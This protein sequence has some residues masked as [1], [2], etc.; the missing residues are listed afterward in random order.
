M[1]V[2]TPPHTLRYA[3]NYGETTSTRVWLSIAALLQALGYAMG[4]PGGYAYV[5][6]T[7]MK[8]LVPLWA[9]CLA[10]LIIG[11][12]GMW[13]AL[14]PKPN[15]RCAWI[16]NVAT[17]FVWMMGLIVRLKMAPV[18]ILTTYGV[19]TVM[20]LWCLLRTEATFRD[21]ASA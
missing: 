2:P 15:P 16:V 4:G 21:T 11:I 1:A 18:M 9:W 10:Y 5:L 12:A 14:D 3:L 7:G 17:L 8:L 13:R 19:V 6:Y 20:S